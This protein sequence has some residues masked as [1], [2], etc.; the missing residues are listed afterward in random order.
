L[1]PIVLNQRPKV[2]DPLVVDFESAEASA[3]VNKDLAVDPPELGMITRDSPAFQ[4]DFAGQVPPGGQSLSRELPHLIGRLPTKSPIN[5]DRAHRV[6][7]E[8][9][10]SDSWAEP[11]A[12]SDTLFTRRGET[13]SSNSLLRSRNCRD[14]NSP[15]IPGTSPIPGSRSKLFATSSEINPATTSVSPDRT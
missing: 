5:P 10:A 4:T 1:H 8:R 14:L 7:L 3:I 2:M 9:A 15:P 6:I 13:K 12:A 11:S